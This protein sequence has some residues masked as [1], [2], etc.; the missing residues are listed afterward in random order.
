[1]QVKICGMRDPD[2]IQEVAALNPDFMGFIFYPPSP[3]YCGNLP[4]DVVRNLPG[5]ILPVAVT[6][7]MDF[8]SILE[9]V[10]RYGF[11]AVQ[12]H[13]NETPDLC[14]KLKSTGLS[15]IKAISVKDAESLNK[16]NT[17]LGSVDLLI[18][19]RATK[20]KG[21]SGKKFDWSLLNNADIRVGFLLSGGISSDDAAEVLS[22]KHPH[23]VGVDLNSR[24][25]ISPGIKSVSQLQ[26]FM[27]AICC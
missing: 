1:M 17:Y 21:G 24:F 10:E 4:E 2:N 20:S 16:V 12:L 22:L 25:E 19:D 3:R 23:M 6:V 5:S 15:V 14:R 18:L 26:N 11:R 27:K 8:D 7:D 13:G 9:L